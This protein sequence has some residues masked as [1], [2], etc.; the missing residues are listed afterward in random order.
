MLLYNAAG[1]FSGK[2]DHHL[3]IAENRA[4][5]YYPMM[6]AARRKVLF[7]RLFGWFRHTAQDE[8]ASSPIH[9]GPIWLSGRRVL[10]NSSYI[11]PK[12][13][14]EGDRLDLQ[15]HLLKIAARGNYRAPMR[16]P[17]V[18]LDVACGTG[19]WGREMAQEF[20]RA[21]V[22]GFDIDRTPLERSLELLGPG[23]QFPTNFHFLTADAT[24]PFPFEDQEFDVS[25]ARLMSPFLPA[26]RWAHVVR[27]M[28]R[29]LR[30]GGVVELV[31][32][33]PWTTTSPAANSLLDAAK[34]LMAGRG[35]YVGGAAPYLADHLR[36]AGLQRVQERRFILGAGS[37]RA[38]QQRL[39]IADVMA[40][41][42]NM[43]PIMVKAG[44]MSHEDYSQTLEAMRTEL[45]SVGLAWPFVFAFGT[46]L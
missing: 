36:Q 19:I 12:D 1:C 24:Q 27:E 28:T 38:R 40:A 16:Q 46:K 5:A 8:K 2:H 7:M 30:R 15:H 20:P 21:R 33:E 10:T 23:G 43:Q 31:D 29:V 41:F 3:P 44:I 32:C 45:T 4:A 18:I 11:L 26:D 25:H 13:K 22:V 9:R 6:S 39:L 37:Q 34:R 42:T 35:L 17:R 14:V